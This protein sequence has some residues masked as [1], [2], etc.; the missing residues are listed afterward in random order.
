M[1]IEISKIIKNI[2]I[3]KNIFKMTIQGNFVEKIKNSGQ[4]INIKINSGNE[5][6]LR[7]PISIS[8]IDRKNKTIDI[9]YKINGKGTKILSEMKE[10]ENIDLIA[11]LG[12]G[13][14]IS[15]LKSGETAL[16]VGGGIGVP[17]LYELGKQ[18]K[19]KGVKIIT[20]L[21]FNS[22]EEI[23][24]KNEFL[25][26][27]E[28][29]IATADGSYG[30]KGFVTDLIKSLKE[31]KKLI[32]DKYFSCG[33][34][35]MLKNLRELEKDKIGYISIENRMACGIGAC[36]ACVCKKTKNKS[37]L[38]DY[39]EK[40]IEYTRVCYDGPVYLANEVEI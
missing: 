25:S 35:P 9:V 7:R 30:H 34:S 12:N 5:F 40:K 32:Y 33:P 29:Y 2:E 15:T 17:P 27:G 18:F 11:P 37:D 13:F 28:V 6:L 23:F 36:Y 10:E 39:D 19:E 20:V 31:N 21:G 14:D 24:Y 8:S 38:I 4:F 16:L 26:L 3:A 1:S 22:K